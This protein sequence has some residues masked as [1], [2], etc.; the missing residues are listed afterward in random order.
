MYSVDFYIFVLIL[1]MFFNRLLMCYLSQV[2]EIVLPLV[3][4]AACG[5][6]IKTLSSLLVNFIPVEGLWLKCCLSKELADIV[7]E[8]NFFSHKITLKKLISNMSF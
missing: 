7:Q 4:V 5:F 8:F 3:V 2:F 1:R 6:S